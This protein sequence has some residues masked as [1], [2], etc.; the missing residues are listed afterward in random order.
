MA[1]LTTLQ[2]RFVEEYTGEA[3]FNATEAAALAGYKGSR[4]TLA[5][6]GSENLRKPKIAEA[7]EERLEEL[8]MSAAE[9]TKRMAD[10]GRGSFAPFVREVGGE[11]VLDLTTD[12]AKQNLHLIS[13]VTQEGEG[14][15]RRIKIK[16]HDAK[17]ATKTLMK[18]HGAFGAKGTEDDPIHTASAVHVYL[19]KNDREAKVDE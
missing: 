3:N 9:A 8:S 6:V 7:I 10:W 19:P 1:D 15:T 11:L 4:A 16:L 14:P 17:D 18:A 13:E 5:A 12:E 2:R